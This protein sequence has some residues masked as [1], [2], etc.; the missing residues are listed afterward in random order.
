M[1]E[2][3]ALEL[4]EVGETDRPA[5]AKARQC[6]FEL[7]LLAHALGGES[8]AAAGSVDHARGKPGAAGAAAGT[9]QRRLDRSFPTRRPRDL[10]LLGVL[11]V[12]L[13]PVEVAGRAKAEDGVEDLVRA[14]DVDP[15][16]ELR[17]VAVL[18]GAV[19]PLCPA[20]VETGSGLHD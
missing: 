6:L 19:D 12:L 17:E 7:C 5:A 10:R 2:L 9:V 16:R 14:V 11:C 3:A 15:E 1:A 8:G 13:D 4:G 18:G 20:R